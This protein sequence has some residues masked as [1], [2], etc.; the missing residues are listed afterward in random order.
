MEA[1]TPSNAAATA[2]VLHEAVGANS[3][4]TE[5][6]AVGAHRMNNGNTG[7]VGGQALV[8]PDPCDVMH[9]VHKAFRG[10]LREITI[11]LLQRIVAD[12][13]ENRHVVALLCLPGIIRAA[14]LTKLVQAH[15]RSKAQTS[16]IPFFG[17]LTRW[18][19]S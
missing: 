11:R 1:T 5:E 7:N 3:A 6:D 13:N 14:Q 10:Q 15:E 19:P 4:A 12:P 2:S 16:L 18:F 17:W 9:D 8:V